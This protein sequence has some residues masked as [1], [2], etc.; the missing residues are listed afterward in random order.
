[1]NTKE[2]FIEYLKSKKVG[3]TAFEV[4]AGLSRGSIA[5]KTGFSADSL[6][7]IASYCTDL[8]ITWLITGEGSMYKNADI[9]IDPEREEKLVNVEEIKPMPTLTGRRG[10]L[11][12]DID[13]TC[14]VMS[15]P[16]DFAVERVIGVVDLPEIKESSPIIRANGDSMEPVIFD[17]DRIVVREVINKSSLF[18]GQIYLIITEEYRMIKYIRKCA[19]DED[20][21]VILRSKNKE[22]DDIK[23]HR[24]E[25]QKLFV[26]ENILSV[27]VQ[28]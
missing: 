1:M 23:L 21:Y 13:A 7:K 8:D 24:G 4:A 17:G 16:M 18:Y 14:G 10:A 26:V 5:K 3:Q 25:I 27:K 9:N 28:L 11:V 12:Y 15:R 20:N 6:E 2:R 19:E 22:Y